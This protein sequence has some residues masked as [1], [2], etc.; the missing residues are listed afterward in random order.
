MKHR[1]ESGFTLV[2]VM[3]T[4]AIIGILATIAYPSYRDY[5]IRGRIPEGLTLLSNE[6]IVMEKFLADNRSYQV[7]G[8]HACARYPVRTKYFDV[9]CDGTETA[10]T[11]TLQATGT[12]SMVNFDYT[13]DQTGDKATVSLGVGWTTFPASCWV[14]KRDGSC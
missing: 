9:A 12:G 5:L 11:Y 2:E 14:L 13:I 6:R 7:G 10:Q 3:V 4:V 8:V 1:R